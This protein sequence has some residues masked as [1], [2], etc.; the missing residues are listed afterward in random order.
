MDEAIQLLPVR[1]CFA[2]IS[3]ARQRTACHRANTISTG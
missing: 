2:S 3:A 1:D